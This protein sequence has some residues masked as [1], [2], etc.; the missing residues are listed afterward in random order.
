MPLSAQPLQPAANPVS[1]RNEEI[2][3]MMHLT[4]YCS[5]CGEERPFEQ[6]HAEPG[7]CP[8]APDA[9]CPEWG[10][11]VCGD[12]LFIGLPAREPVT[13]GSASRAA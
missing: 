7:V 9:D 3:R 10:C 13:S 12:A 11:T 8:D 6:F 2:A 1:H 4:R 5:G